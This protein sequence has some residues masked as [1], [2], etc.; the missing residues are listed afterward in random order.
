MAAIGLLRLAKL[1]D[2]G[3]LLEKAEA[4]LRSSRELLEQAP[5][6][7]AQLLIALDFYLGPVLEFAMVGDLRNDDLP[8]VLHAIWGR[9]RPNKI[10]AFKGTQEGAEIAKLIPL[11][12]GKETVAPVTTYICENYA[13]QAPLLDA[14]A[15]EKALRDRDE[16]KSPATGK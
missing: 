13:C 12:E 2:R 15:V 10:V 8:R 7:A 9:F 3:D 6:A 4:T 14:R 5:Q 11:L 16:L 1:S